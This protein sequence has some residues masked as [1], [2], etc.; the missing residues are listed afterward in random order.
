MV[1]VVR[2][3]VTPSDTFP[4]GADPPSSKTWEM[5]RRAPGLAAQADQGRRARH[6]LPSLQRSAEQFADVSSLREVL[7][8]SS[9]APR[10]SHP[11]AWRRMSRLD[12]AFAQIDRV[13]DMVEV[14]ERK[15]LGEGGTPAR[16]A[17]SASRACGS[18]STPPSL[19]PESRHRRRRRGRHDLAG[20]KRNVVHSACRA[21]RVVT[22]TDGEGANEK[23]YSLL[24][25]GK[26]VQLS[27][28]TPSTRPASS[29]QAVIPPKESI[30][31]FAVRG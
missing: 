8:R 19:R 3:P 18:T 15:L 4:A 1:D 11:E 17:S 25:S 26:M 10:A 5:T 29:A 20:A 6:V 2:G 14:G 28:G 31:S 21:A 7:D 16:S 27:A 23:E 24:P 22:L 9:P 12:D 30:P 13:N